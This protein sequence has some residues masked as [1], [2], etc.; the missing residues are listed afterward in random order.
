MK[1]YQIDPLQ[2]KA[3]PGWTDFPKFVIL[4]Y[5]SYI[6]SMSSS[7]SLQRFHPKQQ[8]QRYCLSFASILLSFMLSGNAQPYEIKHFKN[9][10]GLSNSFIT[11]LFQDSRGIIWIGTTLGLNQFD[12]QQ[13]KAYIP[14]LKLDYSLKGNYIIDVNEDKNGLIWVSSDVGLAVFDPLTRRFFYIH[15]YTTKIKPTTTSKMLT[16]AD[17]NCWLYQYTDNAISIFSIRTNKQLK[18]HIRNNAVTPNDF[19]ITQYTL[20]NSIGKKLKFFHYHKP[21][22]ALIITGFSLLR[23]A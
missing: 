14:N 16:D 18:Y 12:G 10:D 8:F 9:K 4:S 23:K 21:L 13:F 3:M 22:N 2:D 11:C 20:P 5:H 6:Y 15:H 17:G 19:I 7:L 1:L